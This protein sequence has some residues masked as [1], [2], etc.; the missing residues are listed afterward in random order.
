MLLRTMGPQCIAVDE[1]TQE[2]DCVALLEASGCGVDLLAT[3]HGSGL[4]D[5]KRRPIYRKLMDAGVFDRI[6]VLQRDKSW[7]LERMHICI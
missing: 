2:N 6:V 3:A 1:I 4:E 7:R 5:L